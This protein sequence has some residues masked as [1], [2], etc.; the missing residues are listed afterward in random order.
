MATT[1]QQD[2]KPPQFLF[3]V[4]K[5]TEPQAINGLG[6]RPNV[7]LRSLEARDFTNAYL[8]AVER[9]AAGVDEPVP[10]KLTRRVWL[11]ALVTL[12]AVGIAVGLVVL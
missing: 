4:P 5:R 12:A 1:L 2:R 6:A 8:A 11:I 9:K 3:L 10:V 7:Y